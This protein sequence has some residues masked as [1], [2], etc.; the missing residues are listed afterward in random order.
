MKEVISTPLNS[1][2]EVSVPQNQLQQ[3]AMSKRKDHL[4]GLALELISLIAAEANVPL[5]DFGIEGSIALNMHTSK[6]DID[7]VV[8]GSENFRTVERTIGKLVDQGEL[9][10]IFT[11][12]IDQ[13]RRYRGRYKGSIFVYNAVRKIHEIASTYG[14][15]SYRPL[16]HVKCRCDI[17]N[18]E[19][20]MFRPAIYKIAGYQ[21][22]DQASELQGDEGPT[23]LVSMIGY[24]RN[25]A[26]Q[27]EKVEASGMLER[28]ENTENGDIHYQVV[29]GTARN[30]N[31]YISPLESV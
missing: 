19:E 11:N 29:V 10:Y 24:Y 15:Y 28:V 18:D 22:K 5:E 20:A 16:K 14:E 7:F 4:Q 6:S 27:D 26:R 21:P 2:R 23:E 25:V 30:E 31:E 12:Q 3:L 8:Y 9:R 13:H 1:I 17:L